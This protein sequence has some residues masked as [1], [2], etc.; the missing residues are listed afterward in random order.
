M[1]DLNERVA[2]LEQIAATTATALADIRADL[3][4]FREE[5][6]DELRDLRGETHGL[7]EAMRADLH[8]FR[9]E[10]RADL[11]DVR[12]AQRSDFRWL[13]GIMIGGFGVFLAA[14]AALWLK[15]ADLSAQVGALAKLV[16]HLPHAG[17][18]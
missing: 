3:R 1:T 9:D 8:G 6:R 4:T 16:R 13:L 17:G 14:N 5:M 11:R 12:A 10:V 18:G 7:R 15:M 2:V